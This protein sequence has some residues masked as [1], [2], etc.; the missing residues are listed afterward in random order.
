MTTPVR[1]FAE[2]PKQRIAMIGSGGIAGRHLEVLAA[3][4]DVEIVGHVARTKESSA[5]A[6]ARWGGRSYDSVEALLDAVDLD[7]AFV[8]VPPY[9]HDGIDERLIEAGVPFLVEKPLA[10]DRATGARIAAA[11]AERGL[12]V[13]VGYQW[14]AFDTLPAVRDVLAEHPVRFVTG[15][16]HGFLPAPEWWRRQSGSGGQ[17]VE[18]ATHVFDLARHLVGEARV[19]SAAD[20]HFGRPEAPDV[21]G[22]AAA[23]LRF[24]AG[25]L[26]VFAASNVL[27]V[28]T[29]VHLR[30]VC[31]GV[32]VTITREDAVVDD[33]HERRQ[34]RL[35]EDPVA[36]QDRTFL[37]SVRRGDPG[38]PLCTYD[39][40]LRTHHLTFDVLEAATHARDDADAP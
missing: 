22:V 20:G 13:A 40:A 32:A 12:V 2:V 37:D 27:D 39:D 17:M 38:G 4:D 24:D 34:I 30:F 14:R 10:A 11:V 8:T 9:A 19:L 16:W 6:A 28:N 21:A 29:F 31:D 7:A 33:G 35:R 15:V 5:R 36:R 3:M 1:S 25:A 18:Q 23:T 26:G